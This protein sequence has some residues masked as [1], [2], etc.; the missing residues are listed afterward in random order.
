MDSRIL[1]GRIA[2]LFVMA[3]ALVLSLPGSM[4][5]Q[6]GRGGPPPRPADPQGERSRGYHRLLGFHRHR[7][8]AFSH[9]HARQRRLRQRSSES[10]RAAGRPIHGIRP[11]MKPPVNSAS[12]T[13]LRASCAF[14]AALHITW[15]DEN[16]VKVEMD[17][18]D[19]NAHLPF[20]RNARPRMKSH[21][22]RDIQ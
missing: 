7:R 11:K 10:A 1:Q 8:L 19:T 3:A 6:G 22:S 5:G 9:G 4:F 2:P 18:G 21:L 20:Q 16:T 13:V 12:P 15:Q 17:A 14:P